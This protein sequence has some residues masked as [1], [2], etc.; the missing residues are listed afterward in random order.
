MSANKIWQCITCGFIYSESDGIPEEGIA[1]GTKWEDVPEDWCCPD[2][3]M[4]KSDFTMAEVGSN[5][6]GF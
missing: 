5:N 2:C 1:P 3:A 4:D 6:L